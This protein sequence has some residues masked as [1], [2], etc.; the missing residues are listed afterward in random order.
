MSSS[1]PGSAPAPSAASAATKDEGPVAA[2][3]RALVL[4]M[5]EGK[6]G[7]VVK[8]FDAAMSGA[9]PE[10]K[11]AE[12]WGALTRQAGAFAGVSKV[13]VAPAGAY[14]AAVVT[15]R[16]GET[17]LDLKLAFDASGKVSGLFVAPTPP[18]WS[19][20][21]YADAARFE[22]REVIVG[23]EPWALPGTLTLPKGGSKLPAVVLVHGS[24]PGDR[25]ESV[26]PN[27][28]FKDLAAGLASRGVAVLRYEKRTRQHAA[29]I[30]LLS[31]GLDDESVSD[32]L[33]AIDLLAKE[34]SVD[35]ARIYVAGHS[36]GGTFAPRIAQKSQ[37]RVAGVALLAGA[38][39]GVPEMM[40]EQLEYIASL[41]GT[42]GPEEAAQIDGVKQAKKRI[43]ELV[44][45]AKP[46]PSE[47][48]L[49]AGAKYWLEQ[50][51]YD[52]V[53]TAK[54]LDVR[55][56][57]AQGGR[58]YQV[59]EVDFNAWKAAVAGKKGA[60]LK[61]YPALNHLFI[62]GSG[63]SVPDEY[64]RAGHVD[65]ELVVDLAAWLVGG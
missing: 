53:A 26:G 64:M 2:R 49:G 56:F 62:T 37:P 27:R 18:P 6:F 34:P 60:T 11:L 55:F 21:S 47:A 40:I 33:A 41:D 44:A 58:D 24:G 35:P 14:Q 65:E 13:A 9:L 32:A 5:S 42:R 7:E 50:A 59:T 17:L 30:D 43:A 3:A 8:E 15:A 52:P 29:K 51:K 16:F 10:P 63:K 61:L 4:L 45:G 54:G 38:T 31:F 48:V 12:M 19:L 20:P 39:R 46:G 1:P 36:L 57:V 22:E 25:D 23:S 28:P